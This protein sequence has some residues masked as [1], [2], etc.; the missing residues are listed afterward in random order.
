MKRSVLNHLL[1]WGIHVPLFLLVQ[2]LRYPDAPLHLLDKLAYLASFTVPFYGS[3]FLTLPV[4]KKR[5]YSWFTFINLALLGLFLTIQYL[6]DHVFYSYLSPGAEPVPFQP[7]RF[8]AIPTY[9]FLQYYAYGLGYWFA[10]NAIQKEREKRLM[11]AAKNQA[12][13]EA[14]Q[15]ELSFLKSQF[16]PHFLYNTLSYF[17]SKTYALSEGVAEGIMKLSDIM[18]YSLREETDS[19]VFLT[20]EIHYLQN[21]IDIHQLRFNQ[22]LHVVFTVEGEVEKKRILPLVLIS[23]VENAFKHGNLTDA[24]SPLIIQLSAQNGSIHFFLKNKKSTRPDIDSTGI[25][26]GNVKRRLD[27]AY[28]QQYKLKIDEDEKQYSCQLEIHDK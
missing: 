15:A 10:Q 7:F 21:F 27:L 4:Y 17:Y 24:Q 11:E 8:F 2:K 5:R 3:V 14:L 1:V 26:L 13:K 12:E 22:K 28:S 19:R 6:I 25:G 9:H 16:N 18:R 20:E 23:F